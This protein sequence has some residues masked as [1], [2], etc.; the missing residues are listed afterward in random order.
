[1]AMRVLVQFRSS[2]A[3]HAATLRGE[4]MPEFAA[5]TAAPVPGLVVGPGYLPVQVP[6]PVP[7]ELGASPYQYSPA[8]SFST[9]PER[10]TYL[11]RG[12][13]PDDPAAQRAAVAE[14]TARPEVVGVFSDPAISTCLVCPG[15]PPVGDDQAVAELLGVKALAEHLYT[16]L[17]DEAAAAR[18]QDAAPVEGVFGNPRIE[19]FGPP[20]GGQ[21]V[22]GSLDG[23]G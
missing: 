9:A 8:V 22:D 19:P 5:T 10:A 13:V 11:V 6:T 23:P 21:G 3:V 2:P 14:A 20:E 1:M 17:V 18:V 15:D 12:T 16:I 4:A 7:A